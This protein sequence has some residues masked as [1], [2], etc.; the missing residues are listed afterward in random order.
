MKR[1]RI[2]KS[3]KNTKYYL[4]KAAISAAGVVT[5]ASVLVGGLFASPSEVTAPLPQTPPAIVEVYEPETPEEEERVTPRRR[6]SLRERIRESLLA[7]P[8]WLRAVLLVPLWGLGTLVAWLLRTVLPPFL[9][10]L[11][12]AILPLLLLLG[13]LKMLFPDVPVRKLLCKKNR[14][15]LLVLAVLL[16]VTGPVLGRLCPD[17]TN[18]AFFVKLALLA[19]TFLIACAQILT[20]R[21]R[22]AVPARRQ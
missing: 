1:F 4:K 10:W 21:R 2:K 6:K 22:A 3:Q 16:F 14:I 19:L 7:W 13:G 8:Q 11:L 17:R 18:L 12:G 5:A 20:A 15:A 9:K